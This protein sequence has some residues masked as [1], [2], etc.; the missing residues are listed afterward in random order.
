MVANDGADIIQQILIG[1]FPLRNALL[2]FHDQATAEMT[3]VTAVARTQCF[4]T[5]WLQAAMLA[6]T[7]I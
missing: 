5:A 1:E 2:C 7:V 3:V 6:H 4:A